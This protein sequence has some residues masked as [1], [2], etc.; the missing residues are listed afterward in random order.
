MISISEARVREMLCEN[1]EVAERA[2]Q[3]AARAIDSCVPGPE[4]E[5]MRC[6]NLRIHLAICEMPGRIAEQSPFRSK[7]ALRAAVGE[8]MRGVLTKITAASLAMQAFGGGGD[9]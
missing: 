2:V 3:N 4:K 1:I 6:A 9:D 7:A 5:S 8:A